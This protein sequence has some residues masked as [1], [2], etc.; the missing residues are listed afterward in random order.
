MLVLLL[1]CGWLL[2]AQ[3][4]AWN[5]NRMVVGA[6]RSSLRGDGFCK[7][8]GSLPLVSRQFRQ[9]KRLDNVGILFNAD[10]LLEDVRSEPAGRC[11]SFGS[12]R[13]NDEFVLLAINAEDTAN[14][15]I[16]ITAGGGLEN[17]PPNTR[18]TGFGRLRRLISPLS[19]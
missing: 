2:A 19:T 7:R 17:S 15:P 11:F 10:G 14:K 12:E 16:R 3:W 18:T 9:L 4:S 6:L 5:P 1:S 8:S 13:L